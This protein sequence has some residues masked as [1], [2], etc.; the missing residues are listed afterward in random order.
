[1]LINVLF[2]A[3]GVYWCNDVIKRFREDLTELRE[4]EST[5][6]KTV[7]IVLWFVTSVILIF[8]VISTYGVLKQIVPAAFR[9]FIGW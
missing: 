3:L 6:R 4:V 5:I 1:M 8:I 7:I 9:L 2:W